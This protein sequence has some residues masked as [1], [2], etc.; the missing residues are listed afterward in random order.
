MPAKISDEKAQELEAQNRHDEFIAC[1]K[2]LAQTKDDPDGAKRHKELVDVL[3]TIAK[4][5]QP[6]IDKLLSG[7]T[8]KISSLEKKRTDDIAGVVK[9]LTDSIEEV[10]ELLNN[11]PKRFIV[12]RHNDRSI[13]Y[14]VPEY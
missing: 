5:P 2:A 12:E 7:I 11:K 9:S 4:R 3:S 14:I 1:L 8:D 13:A 10:K 6:E